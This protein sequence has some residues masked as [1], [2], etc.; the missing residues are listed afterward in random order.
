MTNMHGTRPNK[1]SHPQLYALHLAS[2]Y[3]LK[4][5]SMGWWP[6]SHPRWG[7][8][9]IMKIIAPATVRS[10]WRMGLLD[11]TPDEKVWDHQ[12]PAYASPKLWTNVKG[13]MLLAE[14]EPTPELPLMRALTN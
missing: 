6:E 7:V 12:P 9:E 10:L 5:S 3:K 4:R 11:G 13:K 14:I 1:L 2:H 8:T